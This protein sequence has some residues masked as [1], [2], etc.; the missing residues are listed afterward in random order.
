MKTVTE[1]L[2]TYAAYHRDRRNIVS[3]FFGI[4]LIVVAVA[5]LL[6]RT[7]ILPGVTPATLLAAACVGYYFM[8]ERT[9]ALAMVVFMGAALWLGQWLAS[10]SQAV[11]LASGVGL[12]VTGWAIQFVGHFWEGRKPAF[13]DD[14]MQLAIG[15]LFIVAEWLFALGLLPALAAEIERR[16][17][18]V[19]GAGKHA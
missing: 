15:P 16:A 2:S 13:V 6:G 17:G 19:R 11:W 4:P 10:G 18:P 3:H 14:L 9:L 1:Q 7:K 5:T 12:F 8:L